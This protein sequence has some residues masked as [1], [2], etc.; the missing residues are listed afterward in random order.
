[1][2]KDISKFVGGKIRSFRKKKGLTQKGL[3]EK[4]GVKHNTI[5]SY[6][7]GTNEAEQNVLFSIANE[8]GVSIN[9][10]FPSDNGGGKELASSN[11]TYYPHSIS[12]GLPDNVESITQADTISIPDEMMGKHAGNSN[13]YISKINGESMNKIIAH[14]SLIAV[15]PV[16]L[17]ELNNGDIVIYN[18]NNEYSAKHFYKQDN[19]VI[20]RPDSTDMSFRDHVIDIDEDID[21]NIKGKV[22]LWVTELD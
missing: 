18:Y 7:N 3:G 14:N 5:S 9:D 1:M 17:S 10:F 15:K 11:Y 6:E 22:V 20:F 4:V 12:A 8:L 2:K 13:I 19:E 16:E 21:L